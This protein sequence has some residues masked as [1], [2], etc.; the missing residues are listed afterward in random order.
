MLDKIK[1]LLGFTDNTKDE[2]ISLLIALCK[3]EATEYCNLD[4][5]SSKLD[6]AVIQMVIEKYN[7]MGAEGLTS[8]SSS[9]VKEE[10]SMTYSKQILNKLRKNRKVRCV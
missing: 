8:V 4:V 9:G 5:Y 10:Y 3:D 1:L 7:Q 2:L 6:S